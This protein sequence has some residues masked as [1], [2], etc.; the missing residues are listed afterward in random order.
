M[1]TERYELRDEPCA[2][3]KWRG[4]IGMVRVN[5]FLVDTIVSCEGDR[6]ESDPPWGIFGGHEGTLAHGKVTPRR[7]ATRSSGRPSSP[8]RRSRPAPRSSSPCPTRAA[9]ATRSKRD[10]AAV[11]SDVLDGFTTVEL[12]R[13]RLRRR[14]RRRG[15][16]GRRGRDREGARGRV[17]ARLRGVVGEAAG[18]GF[19]LRM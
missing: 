6:Y 10:P 1:R 8:A 7:P 5:R 16:D 14:D 12:R 3:G 18:S 13:A 15:H 11:L 4:G 17:T 19:D 2:A 9:T